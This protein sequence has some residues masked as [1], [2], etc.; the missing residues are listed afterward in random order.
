MD[1]ME[2][3][4]RIITN[5]FRLVTIKKSVIHLKPMI[6]H[7]IDNKFLKFIQDWTSIFGNNI[8]RVKKGGYLLWKIN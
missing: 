1:G 8:S 2:R 3:I 7:K 6:L 5:C 4:G